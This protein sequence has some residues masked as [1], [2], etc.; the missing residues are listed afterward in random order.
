MNTSASSPLSS[1]SRWLGSTT[2]TSSRA[3]Y[4]G[5]YWAPTQR[6]L[7]RNIINIVDKLFEKVLRL[8]TKK[9]RYLAQL[10]LIIGG[11]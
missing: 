10:D 8:F 1:P 9:E 6:T 7:F 11:K 4:Q 3:V 5:G 2:S